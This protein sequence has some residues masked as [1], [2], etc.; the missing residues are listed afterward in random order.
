MINKKTTLEELA[1]IVSQELINAGIEAVLT[2]GAVVSIYTKNQ[3]QSYDLDFV[4][5]ES[6]KNIKKVLDKL[7]FKKEEGRHFKHPDTDYFVEF[8]STPLAIGDEQVREKEE[9]KKNNRKLILLPATYSVMD[10]L[11]AYF[12][13]DDPQGLEQ[14]VM[15][16]KSQ[17]INLSKVKTWALKEGQLEKFDVF[18]RL[19]KKKIR[20]RPI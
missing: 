1:F 2:G 18:I 6:V 14:A 5:D 9:L 11:A 19:L 13:W 10:R 7:G 15:V 20:L 12:Y 16:A 4:T 17:K 8:I 3:Y